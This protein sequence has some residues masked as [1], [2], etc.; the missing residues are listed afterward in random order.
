L[1]DSL[2]KMTKNDIKK[3][4]IFD[5]YSQNLKWIKEKTNAKFDTEFEYGV[6]C[7]L[8]LNVFIEKD[9]K[10][11]E[12]NHLTLEHNPPKSLGGKDNILTCKECNNRNGHKTDLELL[13][14]LLEQEFKS[15]SPNSNHRTKLVTKDGAKVTADLSFDNKGKMTF[16]IHS[17]YSNPKD[18]KSFIDSEEKGFFPI[19]GEIGK[20]ATKRY[21]FE[22]P[23]PDK[24]NMRLASISLLKIGYLLGFEKYGHIFLFNKNNEKIREQILNPEKEILTEPFWI[25]YEFPEMYVGV[26]IINEPKELICFLNTFNLKTKSRNVQISIAFPGYYEEDFKI[27]E[28]IKKTLCSSEKGN[29][30]ME[31]TTLEPFLDLKDEDKI[32]SSA[33]IWDRKKAIA[34][35]R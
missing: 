8:C 24:G 20:F 11:S 18:Y 2:K 30:N 32:F 7:P 4:K 15:F 23:I 5:I 25:N 1:C 17:K 28:N 3:K 31:I 9:L 22:I 33:L 12:L 21:K 10:P 16:N 6:L 34:Q 26:N 19:E 27:Y 13:N 14:Y 29:V 35:Q